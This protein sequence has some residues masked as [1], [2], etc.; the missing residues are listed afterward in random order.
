MGRPRTPPEDERGLFESP[1]SRIP[2][3]AEAADRAVGLEA[4]PGRRGELELALTVT[5]CFGRSLLLLPLRVC[6]GEDVA[7]GDQWTEYSTLPVLFPIF[8]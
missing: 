2:V 4:A 7:S 6:S 3:R 5:S 1:I 8:S